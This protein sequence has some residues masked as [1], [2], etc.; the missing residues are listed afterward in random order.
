MRIADVMVMMVCCVIVRVFSVSGC[1]EMLQ[2]VFDR[3]V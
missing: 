3:F 1:A 2:N